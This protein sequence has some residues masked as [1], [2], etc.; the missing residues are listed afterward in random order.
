MNITLIG[1]P[2]AG[3]SYM[4]K[5]LAEKF[6]YTFIDTDT[7]LEN[8]FHKKLQ[9][10]VDNMGSERFIEEETKVILE[11]E[12]RD[13]LI[14]SP[15]GSIVY[16]SRA[17]EVLKRISK[18]IFLNVPIHMLKPRINENNRGIIGMNVKS[19]EELFSE[20][21]PLYIKYAD[22]IIDDNEEK[23]A[24]NMITEIKNTYDIR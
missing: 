20:R 11:L 2:G 16:S 6:D 24:D 9:E 14:I 19:F 4:G 5:I 10:I 18:V 21:F 3:K 7:L 8:K 12:N 13:N 15:G 22:L 1:M 17:M 23:T